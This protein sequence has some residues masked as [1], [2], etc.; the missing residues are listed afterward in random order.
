MKIIKRI[1]EPNKIFGFLIFNFSMALLIFV[2]ANHLEENPIAYIS[3][4]LSS[5]ALI[6]FCIWFYKACKFGNSIFKEK[7]KI[8]KVYKTQNKRIIKASLI[9]SMFINLIYG[10]F[11]LCMGTFYKSEWFITFS[12]YYLLLCFM[13]FSLVF[14]VKNSEFGANLPKEYKKLKHTGIILLLLDIVLSGMI[15]LITHQNQ[16][17]IYPGYLI[18]IVAMYDFYLIIS[19]FVNVLKYRKQ[20]SPI[21]IASKCINLTVAMISM[22]SLE[23]AMIY[24]FGSNDSNLKLVMTA[25]T[26]FGVCIINSFMAIYIIIKANQ[27]M[28]ENK[29]SYNESY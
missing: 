17:I 11:K 29:K 12:V 16:A 21:I 3:Y 22:I 24:Q 27:Y 25:C 6:I 2:F 7:S 19:A 14:S 28:K 13:K 4:L 20:K 5:Y 18:Y 23:V 1:L 9:F 10:I 26:G 8:Y 15:I